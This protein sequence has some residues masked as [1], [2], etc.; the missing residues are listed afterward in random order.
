MAAVLGIVIMVWG[1]YF[2][3]DIIWGPKDHVDVRILRSGSNAQDRGD[4]RNHVL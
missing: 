3:K 2:I 4:A 1:I